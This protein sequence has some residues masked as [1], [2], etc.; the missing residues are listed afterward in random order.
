MNQQTP[1]EAGWRNVELGASDEKFQNLHEFIRKARTQLNQNA[2]DYIIG[3]AETETTLRRNRMALDEIA[4]RPRVLRDV[5][6]VDASVEVFGRRLRL[7]VV[8]APVGALE[9]FDAMGA[10]A[11]ARGAGRFGAAH[12]LS[13]VSEPGLEMTAEAAPDA[14][15]IFQLYVRGDDAF[16]E[17]YVS[18][19]VANRYTAFCLTVD[20]AHYS[21]RERDI[22]KRYVRESRLRA[23]GGDHQKALS[24][25]TVEL[26]KDKFKLPLIIKGIATAEDAQI[27]LDH[28]VDWIYVS[29][30]GGRQLDH[31]R[32]AMHVLPEIVAAV[33][34][35]ARIMVD[36]GFCR[37]TDIVKAIASGA[38]MVGI[39]RLQCWALA[40]AGEDGILRMLELL[41]DEVIRALGLL[42]V[43]SFAELNASYLHPAAATHMPG[44]FSAFPLADIEPYRY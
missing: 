31:G 35:R 20:T 3:G 13:S 37:G 7:P 40:A 5:S 1:I 44:V 9:I 18:R 34:G 11:V 28:G 8:L 41:E 32:G 21:R 42:G 17:D 38:D 2:W 25:R 22:A 16:V 26:I 27:A 24:W 36:G 43:T 23:T 12:M 39:G 15:R 14:L 19:A 4:F 33:K 29:N 30:H 6:R 10:A